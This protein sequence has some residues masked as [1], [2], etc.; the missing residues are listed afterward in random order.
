MWKSLL[1]S[2]GSIKLLDNY[3]Q[4]E[5]ISVGIVYFCLDFGLIWNPQGSKHPTID[6]WVWCFEN[7]QLIIE[8]IDNL[9]SHNFIPIFYGV[10]IKPDLADEILSHFK[11]KPPTF[12]RTSLENVHQI[13]TTSWISGENKIIHDGLPLCGITLKKE[14]NAYHLGPPTKICNQIELETL[15]G[16][17]YFCNLEKLVLTSTP[18]LLIFTGQSGSG[19]SKL[20]EKFKNSGWY[21]MNDKESNKIKRAVSKVDSKVNINFRKLLKNIRDGK[22]FKGIIIDNC[23]PTKVERQIFSSF[24]EDLDLL[25]HVGWITRPG[26]YYNKN[27]VIPAPLEFLDLYSK[28]FEIPDELENVVRLI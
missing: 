3:S 13:I 9:W 11:I 7:H 6:D 12:L 18:S 19:K 16:A 21:V 2:D 10:N 25:Y 17:G 8:Y 23:N 27:K 22:E 26:Y 15:I 28:T 14:F 1:F 4:V 5:S 20:A 24:C